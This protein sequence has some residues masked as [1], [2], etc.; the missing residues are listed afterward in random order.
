MEG[1][2]AARGSDPSSNAGTAGARRRPVA[3][4][5]ADAS[6]WVHGII[7]GVIGYVTV[8]VFLAVASA[9][10]GRSPFHIAA[11]LAD[12]LFGGAVSAGGT[13]IE[14]GPVIAYNGVHL[15]VFL[16]GGVVLA[17]IARLAARVPQGWYFGLIAVLFVAGHV[18]ALPLWFGE[19]VRDA[20]PLWLVAAST[21]LATVAMCAWLWVMN[22]GIRAQMH[23][24]DA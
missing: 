6:V 11:L 12:D 15:V 9:L 1:G 10:Q 21:S 20:L 16:A 4:A 22:P 5:P 17:L 18:V 8:A 19:A 24:P 14:P 3:G 7:A 13:A 2:H 23:E